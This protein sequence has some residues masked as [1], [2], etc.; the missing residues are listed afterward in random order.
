MTDKQ[1]EDDCK[2]E[3]TILLLGTSFTLANCVRYWNKHIRFRQIGEEYYY[4]ANEDHSSR[5]L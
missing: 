1:L 4:E 2:R 3:C 5:R